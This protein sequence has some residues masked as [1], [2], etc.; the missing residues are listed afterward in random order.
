MQFPQPVFDPYMYPYGQPN[1]LAPNMGA[2]HPVQGGGFHKQG[3][4]FQNGGNN[5]HHNKKPHNN[6]GTQNKSNDS[7][8]K[9]KGTKN[10][11]KAD[12]NNNEEPKIT[13]GN[14]DE[15]DAK[16]ENTATATVEKE[17]V[18][19]KEKEVVK[20]KA[21]EVVNKVEKVEEKSKPEVEKVSYCC[22]SIH[23]S[24]HSLIYYHG[25]I[26]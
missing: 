19:E 1:M 13:F 24:R 23:V 21:P 16:T 14:L 6:N 2:M 9:S 20:E 8:D 11:V 22:L 10:K 12:S 3:N 25:N 26:R 18:V 17:A 7:S 5:N 4:N 15:S